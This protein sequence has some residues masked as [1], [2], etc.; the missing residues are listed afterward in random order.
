MKRV[1]LFALVALLCACTPVSVPNASPSA[2]SVSTIV[3]A[4]PRPSHSTLVSVS[5]TP[6]VTPTPYPSNPDVTPSPFPR[7][8]PSVAPREA[9]AGYTGKYLVKVART[10]N[11]V[12][13]YDRGTDGA[14]TDCVQVFICSAGL[15]GR[16]WD[17]TPE[18]TFY[19]THK[20]EW[21]SLYG[22]TFGQYATRIHGSILFHS[23]PYTAT[24]KDTLKYEEYNK[25]GQAASQGCIRMTVADAK[26]IFDHC[27]I[28]TCVMIYDTVAEDALPSP[29]PYI[30]PQNPNRGWD[31]TDPDK[32]NPWKKEPVTEEPVIK[33]TQVASE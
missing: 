4:S 13:V 8:N 16:T 24:R 10:E 27:A 7:K 1:G 9:P 15:Y 20:Y 23:V 5:P 2:S 11:R 30:D 31:P 6:S 22:G 29:A 12:C 25:L 26:W 18:G 33:N 3:P 17:T 32:N 28:G 19:T 21:R 14:Y